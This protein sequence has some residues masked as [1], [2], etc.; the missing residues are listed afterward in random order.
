MR[1]ANWRRRSNRI[2]TTEIPRWSIG[3][4]GSREDSSILIDTSTPNIFC[5]QVDIRFSNIFEKKKVVKQTQNNNSPSTCSFPTVK[6]VFF[7]RHLVYS[8]AL[9]EDEH[10]F[11]SLQAVVEGSLRNKIRKK[12]PTSG[13]HFFLDARLLCT[14]SRYADSWTSFS[15]E[16]DQ[17]ADDSLCSNECRWATK[18]LFC[19]FVVCRSQTN[20]V[21]VF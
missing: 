12:P 13:V 7:S 19:C 5:R 11:K 17:N 6:K 18:I 4:N 15:K 2:Q 10:M 20:C 9:S 8:V 1:T 21:V 3:K 14:S 16:T